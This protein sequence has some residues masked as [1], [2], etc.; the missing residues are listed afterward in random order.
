MSGLE[1]S[2]ELSK[3]KPLVYQVDNYRSQPHN[4][5]WWSQEYSGPLS[6]VLRNTQDL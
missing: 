1:E 4:S 2:V 5:L 3:L 6:M